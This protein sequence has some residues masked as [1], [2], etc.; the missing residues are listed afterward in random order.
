MPPDHS[1]S[2]LCSRPKQ[3][4]C[5]AQPTAPR[6]SPVF[7]ASL[8]AVP[9]C[10]RS[11]L[12][13]VMKSS[14]PGL[15]RSWSDSKLSTTVLCNP[16]GGERRVPWVQKFETIINNTVRPH[17]TEEQMGRGATKKGTVEMAQQEKTLDAKPKDLSSV[18][19]TH[20]VGESHFPQVI[21]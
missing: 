20:A 8:L 7:P 9:G 11:L 14:A 16:W 21:L 13:W 6:L 4:G 3:N 19:E 5:V 15:G 18:P 12:N 1:S 2:V 10:L 17:L